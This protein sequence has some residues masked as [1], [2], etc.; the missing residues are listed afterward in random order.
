MAL[1]P[2]LILLFIGYLVYTF[3]HKKNIFPAPPI[4]V[5]IGLGLS[6]FP[7]FRELN[8]TAE[9]IYHV[10][11][12][13]LLFISAYQFPVRDLRRYGGMILLLSTFGLT[14]AI[15]LT[16]AAIYFIGD[17]F[18]SIPFIAAILIASIL[19]PTDPVSVVQILSKDLNDELVTGVVEGE[20]MIN[21]GTS[22]VAFS[23]LLSWYVQTPPSLLEGLSQFLYV[24]AG[25][26]LIGAAGGWLFSQAVHFT[27]EQRYQIMLSIILT[28]TVFIA[29]EALYVS[30][31]LAVV[32]AGLI[33]SHTLSSSEKEAHFREALNGFWDIIELSILS[34]LFLFIGIVAAPYLLH[35][36]WPAAVIIFIVSLFIRWAVIECSLRIPLSRHR[37]TIK[38][39]F[40]ISIAGV[41]GAVSVYL[42]LE[43]Q[44]Q[45]GGS[46]E[47]ITMISFSL[48]ILSLLLQSFAIHPFAL[49]MSRR[50]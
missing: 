21:D 28:Y 44:E 34:L 47:L 45:S 40:L 1:T 35:S 11:L 13:G 17:W 29:A 31:V 41:K 8:V 39:R 42:I 22:I 23:L 30:G 2:Y 46:I 27:H 49:K 43:V 3:D 7:I 32:T 50:R 6:F 10:L 38:E 24:F 5:F 16:G 9:L 4:L 48:V 20:S 36:Y 33:L 25:G 15:I 14:A 37:P 19:T 12:P 18:F 26:I